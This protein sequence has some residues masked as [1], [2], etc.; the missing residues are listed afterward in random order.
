MQPLGGA[1]ASGRKE[2]PMTSGH[3][4]DVWIS[5]AGVAVSV[6]DVFGFAPRVEK[7]LKSFGE[8]CKRRIESLKENERFER[9]AW[10]I[11]SWT[12]ILC[13]L[14]YVIGTIIDIRAGIIQGARAGLIVRWVIGLVLI[15]LVLGPFLFACVYV[16]VGGAF[17]FLF[18][19]AMLAG[20]VFHLLSLS[21]KGP[22]TAVGLIIAVT[23]FLFLFLT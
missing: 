7:S 18:V 16:A 22:V 13:V 1:G 12:T 3:I 17:F 21:P 2:Q 19:A 9:I 14:L 8:A 5:I 4:V 15:P 6:V 20:A 11:A 10:K 23:G